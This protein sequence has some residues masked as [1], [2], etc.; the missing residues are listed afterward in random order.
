[1]KTNRNIS[2]SLLSAD[3]S[4]LKNEINSVESL[5]VNRLHLDVM[6]GNFVDNLTFGPMI[7]ES[8]RK[9]SHSHLETHLMINNPDK[10]INDY[11]DAGSDTIIIHHEASTD[12]SRDLMLIKDRNVNA[13]IALNPDTD[14]NVIKDY[15][16]L[17]DYVLVMSVYPGF[18]GQKF[19]DSSLSKMSQLVS[20]KENRSILIGVDGGVGLNTIDSVY[21]TG[22]DI[23]IVGS[24]LFGA[25]NISTRYSQL[26]NE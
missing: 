2:P 1:M 22:I 12:V 6:D 15:I 8:I 21:N 16:D 18:G 4:V 10:Y 5:G 9:L 19:M 23:T 3:F 25:D 11:I 24:A 7:I 14:A 20:M 17:L 26:M 13:G